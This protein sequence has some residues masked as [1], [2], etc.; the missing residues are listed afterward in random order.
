MRPLLRRGSY[1]LLGLSTPKIMMRLV[2]CL[3]SS[4]EYLIDIPHQ[5]SGLLQFM[6]RC[7]CNDAGGD[8]SRGLR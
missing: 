7:V 2:D 4:E 8:V 6:R 1:E 3:I 5:P